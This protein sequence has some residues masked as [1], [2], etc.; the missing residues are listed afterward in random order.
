MLSAVCVGESMAVLTPA[1]ALPL[2]QAD[3]LR[4]GVGGAESNV[5]IGLAAHGVT[6]HWIG[7]VGEDGFGTR[8][9]DELQNHGVGIS[10]V[11]LDPVRNTG[12]Y[13]KIAAQP[14]GPRT[15][16]S[17]VLYYRK[18]SAAAAMSPELLASPAAARLIG[19]A[20]LIHL[21]GITPALSAD[22]LDLCRAILTA[23]REGRTISFDVN[24]RKSLWAGQDHSVLRELANL[25]DV[26][27]VGSDE[28]EHAF[29][30]SDEEEMRSLLPDPAVLVIKNDAISAIT[31]NRS[32]VREEVPALSVDVVEPVG[33]GDAFAAGYLSG[34]LS[35]LD[36][37]A[38][39]R[40]G[41]LSAACTLTV[42]GDRGPLPGADVQAALEQSS[43]AHWL[44][45]HVAAGRITSPALDNLAGSISLPLEKADT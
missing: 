14:S 35:G 27:L 37:K 30:T 15:G 22:C 38:S 11:E 26:V 19:D 20:Q 42:R 24:W 4:V 23:P 28:A 6:T 18:G 31:L 12:V 2:D 7:R 29:G 44:Q 1:R 10:G 17:S 8:I 43:D 33:A 21:S 32:G 3:I 40:R 13:V 16:S 41:H 39:L 9:L 25:A 34:M 5:A 45:T 36:P